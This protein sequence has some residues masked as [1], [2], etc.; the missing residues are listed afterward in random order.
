[1]IE[2]WKFYKESNSRPW[3]HR[4]YY[5]SNWGRVKCNGELYKCTICKGYY[6]LFRKPLHRIVAELFIPGWDE[7]CE[8]DHKDCNRLNNRVDN[9]LLCKDHKQNMNNPLSIQ[10]QIESHQG[11]PIL[12]Y[13]KDNKLVKGYVSIKEAARQTKIHRSSIISCCQHRYKSA[14]GYIWK[15]KEG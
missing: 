5:V 11:K 14:G 13:T 2:I 6:Y 9:L 4:V 8:I 7:K 10:N 3:G 1:M 12:Q 15:Y